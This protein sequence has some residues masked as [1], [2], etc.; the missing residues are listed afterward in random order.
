MR[1]P[2]GIMN[3]SFILESHR[4]MPRIAI[5]ELMALTFDV[6]AHVSLSPCRETIGTR[7]PLCPD[8]VSKFNTS[9]INLDTTKERLA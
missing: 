2:V 4:E 6:G 8:S 3:I 7:L 5:N 1:H 9:S